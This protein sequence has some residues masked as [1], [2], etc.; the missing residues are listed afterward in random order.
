LLIKVSQFTGHSLLFGLVITLQ[1]RFEKQ[2]S[3]H[4]EQDEQFDEDEHPKHSAPR[5]LPESIHIEIE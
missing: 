4:D 3:E 1:E 2:E 5:H